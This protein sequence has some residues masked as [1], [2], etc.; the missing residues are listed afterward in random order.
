MVEGAENLSYFG[1]CPIF[2]NMK[3]IPSLLESVCKIG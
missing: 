1:Y 2:D 3:M